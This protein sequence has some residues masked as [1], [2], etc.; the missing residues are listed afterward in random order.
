MLVAGR[1][2]RVAMSPHR[3]RGKM[4]ADGEWKV[5]LTSRQS[6]SVCPKIGWF[7]FTIKKDS[8]LST[9]WLKDITEFDF[10]W[11]NLKIMASRVLNS[12]RIVQALPHMGMCNGQLGP[13]EDLV[14]HTKNIPASNWVSTCPEHSLHQNYLYLGSKQLT[15]LVARCTTLGKPP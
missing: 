12:L 2:W 3:R 10:I 5:Y 6:R 15:P 9:D 14:S 8:K 7:R 1:R 4:W 11:Y 13:S